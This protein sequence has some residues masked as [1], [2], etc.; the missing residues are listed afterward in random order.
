MI[1]AILS[2]LEKVKRTGH[3]TW[4]AACPAHDDKHPSMTLRECEDGRILAH[5]HGGCSIE[6]IVSAV[7]L[8]WE[9]WFPEKPLEFAK[10]ERRPF[11]AAD[12]LAALVDESRIVAVAA[13]NLRNGLTLTDADHERLMIAAERILEAR[14]VSL[15]EH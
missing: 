8:D 14:S 10:P 1:D 13:S 3:G 2:R 4:I 6:Q 9:A 7:G 11:P 12:V 15:G 5:C